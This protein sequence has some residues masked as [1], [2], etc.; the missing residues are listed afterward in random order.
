MLC[1]RNEAKSM[2]TAGM[3][4]MARRMNST[5]EDVTSAAWPSVAGTNPAR[6]SPHPKSELPAADAVLFRK[7]ARPN[8]SAVAIPPEVSATRA[9]R[10]QKSAIAGAYTTH[11]KAHTPRREAEEDAGRK[12]YTHERSPAPA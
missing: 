12:K 5:V 7:Q 6:E 8:T 9:R 11:R 10:V 3:N 2:N 1:T 4:A